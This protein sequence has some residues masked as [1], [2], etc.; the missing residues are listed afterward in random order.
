MPAGSDGITTATAG[1]RLDIRVLG[2]LRVRRGSAELP[3]GGVRE[4]TLLALLVACGDGGIDGDRIAEELWE[5]RP[6]RGAA[7]TV[8]TYAT[9]LRRSLDDTPTRSAVLVQHGVYQLR[10]EAYAC[11]AAELEQ[12]LKQAAGAAGAE[13]RADLYGRAARLRRGRAYGDVTQTPLIVAEAARLDDLLML[14]EEERLQAELDLGL[15][16]RAVAD[17][18]ALVAADP[19]SER[20]VHLL[21]LALYRSGRHLEA[22]RT[23]QSYRSRLREETGIDPGRR[24]IG[25]E[26][27]ILIRDPEL[28]WRAVEER[29]HAV[30]LLA[31]PHPAGARVA[32]EHGRR[33]LAE[34]RHAEAGAVLESALSSAVEPSSEQSAEVACDILL[35]LAES[36]FD[37]RDLVGSRSAAIAAA[38]LAREIGSATRVAMAASWAGSQS[39]VGHPDPV[40]EELC[41]EALDSLPRGEVALRARVLAALA[42]YECFAVGQGDRALRTAT[43]ALELADAS[44]DPKLVARCLFQTGESLD[45]TARAAERTIIAERLVEH[46]L[47]HGDPEAERE[48]LHL[49]ALV[50]LSL[51]DLEG[52]DG[53][54]S[55]LAQLAEEV[56]GWHRNVFLRLWRGTRSMMDGR[57][58]QVEASISELLALASHEP[59]I[60][61]L[62]FGQLL[63]LRHEQGRLAEMRPVL[64]QHLARERALL[65][66]S[67]VTAIAHLEAGDAARAREQLHA[68]VD[69][70]TVA[71]PRDLTWTTS[72]VLLTEA[73]AA[74]GDR[75]AAGP[76]LRELEPF[77]GQL[78]VL[79]KGI[80][81]TGAFDRYAGMLQAVLGD[82]GAGA[83]MEAA[84]ALESA[85]GMPRLAL[86][87]QACL[88]RWLRGREDPQER[89]RGGA[90]LAEVRDAAVRLGMPRLAAS[91][92]AGSA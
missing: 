85:M 3:G 51:G 57:Y 48:G 77:R 42:D 6:P 79:S 21:V 34:G 56:P 32:L 81:V 59:N 63:F 11:D 50:R 66:F 70:T 14:A 84:I 76:L 13:D 35:G 22:L 43:E 17:L 49:R 20:P 18:R 46:S 74:L 38:D 91:A 55:R 24:L 2:P 29:R 26:R 44:D 4:R 88:G 68:L 89:R 39:T 33:L 78:A 31:G 90:L 10:P 67:A 58:D 15:H 62:A 53:D 1:A 60:Q 73:A 82:E 87:S 86:R 12:L 54:R 37:T 72:L 75:A 80:A 92:G 25:L 83:S 19:H 5:G 8:R 69:G 45:W 7:T 47:T 40:V 30:R 23:L 41:R 27:A 28:E 52:F 71:V 16:R 9:R 36:R 61:N 64:Q 65:V